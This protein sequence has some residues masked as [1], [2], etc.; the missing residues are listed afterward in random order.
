MANKPIDSWEEEMEITRRHLA[1]AGALAFGMSSLL[2]GAPS[3]AESA[4]NASVAK[5]LRP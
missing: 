5:R 2:W 1:A 4:E 3:L